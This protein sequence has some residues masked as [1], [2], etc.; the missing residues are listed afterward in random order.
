MLH[1]LGI[2]VSRSCALIASSMLLATAL[3]AVAAPAAIV[4]QVGV[5]DDSYILG[6][7]DGLDLK[8]LDASELS[9]PLDVL[10]DGT[11]SLPL[12]GSVR[13]V[14][15]TVP[16]ATYWF[17]AL[18]AKQ[19][20]RPDLQLRVV[21]PRPIRVALVGEVERPGL[22]SLTTSEASQVQGVAA[23]ISGLP[24]VVDAI[25]K[26]GGITQLADLRHV[27]LQRR[28]PGERVAYKQ[29]RLDLM[30]LVLQGDQIQNP[31]LFDGDTI[32]LE[33][34]SEPAV[35]AVELAAANLSP[36]TISV[37]VIGEVDRPGPVQLMA[38]TPLSQAVL[39][40]GGPKAWRANQGKVQLIRINRNGTASLETFKLNLAQGVSNAEN[41]PLRDGD[42]V[43]VTS[44]LFAQATDSL[45][46]VSQPLSGLV[47][48][49]TLL[50]LIN[51]N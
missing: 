20:L 5:Q 40:A 47:Q 30:A 14:G 12:V 10:N 16:Q 45:G 36:K 13:V 32:R 4:S 11:V 37:N 17:R 27:V 8:V 18:L 7:G 49:W 28:L 48:M 50:R 42:T 44:N 51:T 22:Y 26:A 2:A 9:G 35:E 21:R 23:S 25:Q 19:L 38:N 29:A 31:Y 15:L 6:P 33:R 46:A 1:W 34:A 39:A 41:P 43:K 24:T 3:P